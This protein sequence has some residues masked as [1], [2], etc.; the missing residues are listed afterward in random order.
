MVEKIKAVAEAFFAE[1]RDHA[2][3]SG[4]FRAAIAAALAEAEMMN[5]RAEQAGAEWKRAGEAW[6][7]RE[8][9]RFVDG[10]A[11]CAFDPDEIDILDQFFGSGDG[12]VNW[13]TNRVCRKCLHQYNDRVKHVCNDKEPK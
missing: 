3:Y 5:E 7:G 13:D 11:R 1:T 10:S 4:G 9:T 12:H 6:W 8:M 2:E